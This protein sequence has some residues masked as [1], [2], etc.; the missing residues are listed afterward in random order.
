MMLRPQLFAAVFSLWDWLVF[1][2]GALDAVFFLIKARRHEDL[3]G[4]WRG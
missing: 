3:C 2:K 1:H 4:V